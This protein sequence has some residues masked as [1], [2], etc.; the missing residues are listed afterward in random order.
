VPVKQKLLT[1]RSDFLLVSRASFFCPNLVFCS[2][3]K[4]FVRSWLWKT[5]IYVWQFR[6]TAQM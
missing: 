3:P 1:Q 4:A 5:K 2:M 6:S